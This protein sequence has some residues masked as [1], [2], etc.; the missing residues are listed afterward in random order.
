MLLTDRAA[1]EPLDLSTGREE[2][3]AR[4]L[5]VATNGQCCTGSDS[6]DGALGAER[7]SFGIVGAS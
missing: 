5:A 7:G 3:G 1:C 4:E 6:Q 2:V